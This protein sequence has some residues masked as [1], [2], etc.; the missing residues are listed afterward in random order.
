MRILTC[1]AVQTVGHA[2][3]FEDASGNWWAVALSTRGGPEYKYFPMVRETVLTPVT[4]KKGQWPYATQINGVVSAW[5]L[6]K[7]NTNIPGSG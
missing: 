2:D 4:W 7:Q 3:F 5:R 6:P 1:L